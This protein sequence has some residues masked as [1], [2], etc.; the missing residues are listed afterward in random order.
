M[1]VQ[2]PVSL[3]YTLYDLYAVDN[4][5]KT[6]PDLFYYPFGFKVDESLPV[7]FV[8]NLGLDTEIKSTADP[9]ALMEMVVRGLAQRYSFCA[10]KLHIIFP[11]STFGD[12]KESPNQVELEKTFSQIHHDQIPNISFVTSPADVILSP[13]TGIAVVV[14][15]DSILAIPHA[16]D[17]DTHYEL[18]SKRGLAFSGLPTPPTVVIDAGIGPDD[19]QDPQQLQQAMQ[20][21]LEPLETYQIPFFVKLNQSV[22][23]K[24]VFAVTSEAHRERIKKILGVRLQ[25]MLRQINGINS[26]LYPSSFILQ[27]Y[28]P[29]KVV[30]LSMFVTQKGR[31]IFNACCKQRFDSRGYWI[32]GQIC[33]PD[34]EA[35]KQKYAGTM[36]RIAEFLHQRGYYGPAGA[37]I[38]TAD[39]GKHYTID[40]NVRVTGT[41][42]LGPLAGHFTQRGLNNAMTITEYFTCSRSDF[43]RVFKAEIADGVLIICSW[44]REEAIGLSHGGVTIGAANNEKLESL[45]A[46]ILSLSGI[47]KAVSDDSH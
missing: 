11:I 36:N 44:V 32:G 34:Q 23:G 20:Q 17:P 47:P 37:D 43:E 5:G 39:D 19:I 28:I 12:S 18:L 26:H 4:D 33:Y 25:E 30:A 2:A 29:G 31:A 40:L 24:G 46:R 9:N 13:E 7:K 45:L 15:T 42:P 21:M 3:D 14:P 16:V 6:R 1:L 41:H 35:L 27:D 38:V 10:G 8:Y 22:S